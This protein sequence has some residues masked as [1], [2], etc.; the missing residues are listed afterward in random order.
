MSTVQPPVA[1]SK[2]DTN[3]ALLAHILG[4]FTSFVGALVIWLIKKD[5]SAYVGAQALEALNFQITIAIGWI[6]CMILTVVLIGALLIP[7]LFIVNLIFCIL[8]AMAASRG[9]MYRYPFALRLL[10]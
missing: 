4:I 6:V 10:K 1:P 3:L 2:D 8:G 9:E 5:D 7:V